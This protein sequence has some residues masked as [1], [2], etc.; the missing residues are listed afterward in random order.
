MVRLSV[1]LR[2]LMG[3]ARTWDEPDGEVLARR[4]CPLGPSNA[5]ARISG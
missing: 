3:V 1:K 2:F 5:R 4:L